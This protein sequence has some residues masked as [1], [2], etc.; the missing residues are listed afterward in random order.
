MD[1]ATYER[2]MVVNRAGYERLREQIRRD[3]AG[4]YVALAGGQVVAAKPTYEEALAAVEQLRPVPS[5]FLV[6][7]ADEEPDFQPFD[8]F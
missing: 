1:L 5:C 4:Q 3:H 7:P 6:F 8:D 2:E